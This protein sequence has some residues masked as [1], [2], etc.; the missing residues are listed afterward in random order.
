M[1]IF[2]GK[3]KYVN[4]TNANSGNLINHCSINLTQFKDPLCYLCLAGTV[5]APWALTQEVACSK[6]F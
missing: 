3:S 1:Y 4:C 6:S 5:V 2:F